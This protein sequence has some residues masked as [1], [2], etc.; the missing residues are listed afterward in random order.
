MRVRTTDAAVS[1][2]SKRQFD[3]ECLISTTK[4]KRKLCS[5]L[6]PILAYDNMCNLAK[7]KAAR[8]PLPFKPPND[9]LW[10]QVN[11]IIDI[12]HFKNH[13]GTQC[14]EKFSPLPLKEKHPSFKTQAGEQTFSWLSRFKFNVCSMNKEHRLFFIHRMVLRENAYTSKCYKNGQKPI[15]PKGKC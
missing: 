8:K 6:S 11:K 1:N 9:Q 12:F 2:A 15:L 4:K 7:I 10:A 13:I 3:I 14:R 5:S